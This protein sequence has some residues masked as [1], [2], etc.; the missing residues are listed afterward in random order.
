MV[1][2]LYIFKF[3]SLIKFS[4]YPF[5]PKEHYINILK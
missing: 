3:L 2:E 5:S 1:S 4:F